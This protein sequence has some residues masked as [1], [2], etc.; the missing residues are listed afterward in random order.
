MVVE[1]VEA[2]ARF[3]FLGEEKTISVTTFRKSGDGVA[4]ISKFFNTLGHV[5]DGPFPYGDT[6][7]IISVDA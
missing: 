3:I 5:G 4:T 2:C 7:V 1:F 6:G